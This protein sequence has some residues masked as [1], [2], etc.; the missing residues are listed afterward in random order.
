MKSG[1]AMINFKIGCKVKLEE[2]RQM[3]AFDRSE[4]TLVEIKETEE[5]KIAA[6]ALHCYNIFGERNNNNDDDANNNN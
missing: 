6:K 2:G 3:S 1:L 4:N 5:E